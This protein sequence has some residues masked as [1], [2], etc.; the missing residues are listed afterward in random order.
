MLISLNWIKDFVKLPEIGI[1]DI[2]NDFTMKTAEVEGVEK[3]N[4]HLT[5]IKTAKIL[6]FKKHPEADKLNLVTF[7]YGS[8]TA[9]VVCGAPNVRDGLIVAYAPI[10]V[11]LPN[12]LTLEPKKIRGVLSEGMLCSESELGLGEGAKGIMELPEGTKLGITMTEFLGAQEDYIIDVDNKSL[13][14]RPDLWGMFGIARE[15]AAI[16]DNPL[17][18]KFTAD[19][20]K[21]L[22]SKFTKDA[23]PIV[24]KVAKDC[25]GKAF[26]GLSVD[27]VKVE[28][29]PQWIQERLNAV[30]LRPINNIVDISNYVMMELGMPLHI[31]DRESIKNDTIEVKLAG[32]EQSFTTLDEIERKVLPTD[33]VICDSEKP[34]VLAGIMGGANS[35]VND[36]TT[37]VFIE[38][39]NWKAEE[40]RKT[41]VHLGLRTDSSSRYEK[42]LDSHL[43]YRTL[44]RTL[45]LL[46]ELCPGA[47]V[48]GKAE[49]DGDDL[50]ADRPLEITTSSKYINTL[51]G[52]ELSFDE[53]K[54]ILT[55]LDFQVGEERDTFDILVPSYRSTKDIEGQHDIAEEVGRIV[56]YDNI[57]VKS[58]MLGVNPV[59]LTPYK[60]VERKVQDFM[61]LKANALEV[62]SYPLVGKKLLEKASWENLNDGMVLVNALS[63]DADRMRPSLIPSLLEMAS[64]NTKN[65]SRYRFFEWG[66]AYLPEGKNFVNERNILSIAFF[67]KE[68]TPFL[69]L[70]NIV[71][72]FLKFMKL[73]AK[74]LGEGELKGE[75]PLMPSSWRGKHPY[76]YQ[77]IFIRGKALGVVSSVHPIVLRDFKIKGHLSIAQFDLTDF[78]KTEIKAKESYKPL[79]KFPAAQFD[80]TV[81]VEKDQQAANVLTVQKKLKIKDLK[82]MKI[83]Q[84]YPLNDTQNSVTVRFSYENPEKT[85]EPEVIKSYEDQCVGQLESAGFPL[86]S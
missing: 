36:N 9:E 35:G 69:Q 71:E 81:L 18:H 4:V 16:Y 57:P 52:T 86:K 77:D 25:S 61:S 27:G 59:G 5:Q 29:S 6:S 10:G 63:T 58:P 2:A 82:S 13:T 32:K 73:P 41:S 40:V 62:M 70:L 78:T 48:I 83:V 24:P 19:W 47:K 39:A 43:T 42:S 12:G 74:F 60:Q 79:A 75:N 22:E 67:H 53:I 30:G 54:K 38:V 56:G 45:E 7:D 23:S 33:T 14:H 15:F 46:C 8:G 85:L 26:W 50:N 64:L 68:R 11:T 80:C 72:D 28:D 65:F 21:D 44:L 55:N 66:R 34:L 51:L 84:V 31:Y 1:H 76:E 49:Y 17:S 20:Y 37:K 3:R